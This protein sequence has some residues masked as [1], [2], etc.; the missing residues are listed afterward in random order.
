MKGFAHIILVI[1]IVVVVIILLVITHHNGLW[2]GT[3]IP[4]TTPAQEY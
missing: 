2:G 4:T 1:I 3:P